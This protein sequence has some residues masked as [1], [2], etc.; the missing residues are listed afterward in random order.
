M[1]ESTKTANNA[2]TDINV[3]VL[4]ISAQGFFSAHK[5]L[6]RKFIMQYLVKHAPSV[7]SNEETKGKKKRTLLQNSFTESIL[8]SEWARPRPWTCYEWYGNRSCC[9]F[10]LPKVMCDIFSVVLL[11]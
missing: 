3:E 2:C 9:S 4:L 1:Q 7:N 11:I 10:T 5:L 8:C 6:L